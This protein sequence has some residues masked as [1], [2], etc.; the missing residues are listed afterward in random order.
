MK[1][2]RR[3]QRESRARDESNYW[4][5]AARQQ[6][7]HKTKQCSTKERRTQ[8]NSNDNNNNYYNGSISNSSRQTT[9]ELKFNFNRQKEQREHGV[10]ENQQRAR[11]SARRSEYVGEREE[12][13]DVE[14]RK[15]QTYPLT[16]HI[17]IIH[18]HVHM[19]INPCICTYIMGIMACRQINFQPSNGNFMHTHAHAHVY[20]CLYVYKI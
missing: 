2:V 16:T 17:H 1:R 15:R 19:Y 4:R 5:L 13:W 8:S 3:E 11:D 20:T 18:M 14:S 10:Q 7:S 12:A 9:V 6:G